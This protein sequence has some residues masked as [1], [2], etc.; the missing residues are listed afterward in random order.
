MN[1]T[2]E[3]IETAMAH[4]EDRRWR[5]RMVQMAAT[6]K[7]GIFDDYHPDAIREKIAGLQALLKEAG[8]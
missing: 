5:V 3:E 2:R 7:R 8:V 1:L 6:R 4:E